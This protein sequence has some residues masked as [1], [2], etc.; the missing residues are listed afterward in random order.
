MRSMT[1]LTAGCTL[2][3]QQLAKTKRELLTL[4]GRTSEKQ[5]K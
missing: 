2:I 4:E 3:A 5:G 1:F